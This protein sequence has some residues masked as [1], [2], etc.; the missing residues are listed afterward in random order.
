MLNVVPR[1]GVQSSTHRPGGFT[2]LAS[3]LNHVTAIGLST[4]AP[5]RKFLLCISAAE[6]LKPPAWSSKKGRETSGPSVRL[7]QVRPKR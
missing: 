3:A 1:S 4:A 7:K 2:G 5:T 6:P